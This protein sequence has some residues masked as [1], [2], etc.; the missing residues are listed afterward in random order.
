[1]SKRGP[2]KTAL[3]HFNSWC[4]SRLDGPMHRALGERKRALFS[5]LPERI[6]EIGP[7]L[8]AN[9]RY[10]RPGTHV[11]A[12]E[13]S[14]FMHDALRA[15]AH[16]YDL[17]LEIQETWAE[18]LTL[19]DESV[20]AVVGT[21]LLCSVRAPEQVMGNVRRVLRPGGKFVFLEHVAAPAGST[22]RVVQ[23]ALSPP[24]RVVFEGCEPNRNTR[25]LIEATGFANLHVD[26]YVARSPYYPINSQI[27]GWA[28]K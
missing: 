15:A 16:R 13:P 7:G 20:D 26:E 3:G 22:R 24:W 8:G 23:N 6:L 21:L 11:V 2:V 25:A 28:E 14:P 1:L 4:L 9:F 19:E 5:E 18:K 12:L 10:Y 27:A 17:S